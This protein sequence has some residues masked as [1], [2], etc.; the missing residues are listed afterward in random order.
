MRTRSPSPSPAA[1]TLLRGPSLLLATLL[2][3]CGGSAS[4]GHGGGEPHA[5]HPHGDHATAAASS[6]ASDSSAAAATAHSGAEAGD[7]DAR[8]TNPHADHPHADHHAT[9]PHGDHATVHHRFDDAEKWAKVFDD[10]ERDAWQKPAE[11]VA[12]LQIAPASAVADIGAGTGYFNPHLARAVGPEGAVIAV[13]IEQSLVDHMTRRATTEQTPQVTARLGAPDD[14]KLAP[15]EVDLVLLVD[16]YH[17]IGERIDYFTRLAETL[18]PGG[19]LVVVDFIKDK[20]V[21][22]GPKPS[23]RIAAAK[24]TAEL[25]EAGWVASTPIDVLPYQYVLVFG[26]P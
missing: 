20:D 5:D 7:A 14:P 24:V 11:L 1:P 19:R 2:A 25:A 3:A 17:H 12:A 13:D 21:P 18:K 4:H 8:A 6:T 16:T 26:R 23:H 15:G 9:N 22:V 10:P